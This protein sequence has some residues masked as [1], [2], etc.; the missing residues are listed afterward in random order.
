MD[1]VE[2]PAH[3]SHLSTKTSQEIVKY[4]F[5]IKIYYVYGPALTYQ[6]NLAIREKKRASSAGL[7]LNEPI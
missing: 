2:Y 3:C 5:E 6:P 4:Y 1:L 7:R